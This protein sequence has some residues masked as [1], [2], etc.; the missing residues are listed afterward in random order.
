LRYFLAVAQTENST[1]AAERLRITQPSVSQQIAHLECALR[2]P[3][4]RRIGKRVRLTEAG[5]AFRAPRPR[6]IPLEGRIQGIDFGILW[7]LP[8]SASPTALAASL[9][10]R[11]W[12]PDRD[13]NAELARGA[14]AERV[15]EP[16]RI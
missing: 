11:P 13:P 1:R 15:A 5:A 8:G 16:L 2:T 10:R 7:P 12:G 14:S 3:L 9:K 4:F 6:A